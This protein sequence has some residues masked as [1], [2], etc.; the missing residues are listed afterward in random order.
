M[1]SLPGEGFQGYRG[2]QRE[3]RAAG[4]VRVGQASRTLHWHSES[5]LTCDL[6]GK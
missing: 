2:Q 4:E 1:C 6:R 3:Q 5:E